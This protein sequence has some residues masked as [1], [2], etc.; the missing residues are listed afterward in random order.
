[1]H[2]PLLAGQSNHRYGTAMY[3]YHGATPTCSPCCF[4]MVRKR[5]LS[6]LVYGMVVKRRLFRLITGFAAQA[7][8]STTKRLVRQFYQLSHT[9][10]GEIGAVAGLQ[11]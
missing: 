1:M 9:C 8:R 3:I 5:E 11:S 4:P 10:Y 6:P 2:L 7:S